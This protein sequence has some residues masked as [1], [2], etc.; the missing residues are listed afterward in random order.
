MEEQK[1]Q[2][3]MQDKDTRQ[4]SQELEKNAQIAYREVPTQEE[5]LN[6]GQSPQEFQP[7]K[8]ADPKLTQEIDNALDEAAQQGNIGGG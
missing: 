4:R 6:G 3:T 2:P 8:A 5:M 7:K 1:Q